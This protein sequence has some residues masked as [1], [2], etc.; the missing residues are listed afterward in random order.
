MIA[1]TG[2]ELMAG[3]RLLLA[4]ATFQISPGDKVGLV[5]RNGAGKTT[6]ARV[7]AGEALPAAGTVQRRGTIGYLP[8]DSRAGD[9]DRRWPWTGCCPARGLDE[10]TGRHAGRRGSHGRSASRPAATPRSAGTR[11]WRSGWWCSAGTRPRRRRRPSRPAWACL[12]GC[13]ASRCAPCRAASGAGWSWPGSC[14]ADA[15]TLLLDEPTNHLDADSIAW[16]RD[17]L[18]GFRGGLVV[19]SHDTALLDAVVSKVFHLDADR[20]VLD[21]YNVGWKAYLDQR[22]TDARRRK[23]ERAQRRSGRRPPCRRRPT[24]CGPRRPR[25]GP[26]R[27]WQRRAERLLAGR[28]CRAARRSGSRGCASRCPRPAGRSR[29]RRRTCPSPTGRSRCSPASTWRWTGARGS[30]CSASTGRARPRCCGCWPGW[31]SP[32]PAR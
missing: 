18:R 20:A 30:W 19:I 1:A 23:R 6:L 29:S 2:L 22:E 12:T 7:L 25:P 15:Q 28:E 4:E 27:A 5:G 32:T 13:W 9:L 14:S 10:R 24:R 31:S 17:H 11:R 8:Q 3:A 26:R 16:L 21:I